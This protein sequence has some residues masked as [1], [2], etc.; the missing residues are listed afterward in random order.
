M[1]ISAHIQ[2]DV[3]GDIIVE[4]KG[5]LEYESGQMLYDELAALLKNHPASFITLDF[6]HVE[7]VGSSG[8]GKFVATYN[9]LTKITDKL[10]LRHLKPEFVKVFRLYK[11]EGIENLAEQAEQEATSLTQFNKLK[12]TYDNVA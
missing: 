2:T 1:S 3:N 9:A 5:A 10:R 8:I 11:L 7:F 12:K 4:L 6:C